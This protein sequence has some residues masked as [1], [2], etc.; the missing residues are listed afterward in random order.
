MY[1]PAGTVETANVTGK[2]KEEPVK[3][4]VVSEARTSRETTEEK[5]VPEARA[6]KGPGE[7]RA[8]MPAVDGRPVVKAP[9]KTPVGVVKGQT[10]YST[11]SKSQITISRP[12]T[13][14]SRIAERRVGMGRGLYARRA[15]ERVGR[16]ETRVRDEVVEE[17]FRDDVESITLN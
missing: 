12:P 6:S 17:L 9:S 1:R 2:S 11:T 10:R 5:G 13:P 15:A 4:K 3:V 14:G 16:P 8:K 7:V